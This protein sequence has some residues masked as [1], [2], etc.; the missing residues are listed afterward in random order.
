MRQLRSVVLG[1]FA[2]FLIAGAA[3]AQKMEFTAT[4][5]GASEVPPTNS[6]G[7]GSATATLD[8]ASKMLTWNVAYSGLSGPPTAAHIHGPAA[9]GKNAGVVIPFTGSLDSPIKGSKTLT[10]AQ[11]TDLEAGKDYVNI[12]T[13]AHKG[14]EIRGQLMKAP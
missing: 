3:H 12:H 5:S 9:P 7:T 10:A 8:P 1:V 4:L 11:I 13:A 14:G 6:P 2:A